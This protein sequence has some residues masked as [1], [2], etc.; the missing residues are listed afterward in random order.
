MVNCQDIKDK[1]SAWI[2][3]ELDS[4]ESSEVSSHIDQC[5]VCRNKV[6]LER[7]TKKMV[8]TKVT[9]VSSPANLQMKIQSQLAQESS[10]KSWFEKLLDIRLRPLSVGVALAG[11]IIALVGY[12]YWLSPTPGTNSYPTTGVA[13]WWVCQGAYHCHELSEAGKFQLE[14]K[15]GSPQSIIQQVNLQNKRD[16][17]MEL[18]EYD[19]Q[20]F[21]LVGSKFC[22]LSNK[23]SI[24][25][26]FQCKGHL[27][28]LEMINAKGV[29]FKFSLF[30]LIKLL[31]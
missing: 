29:K 24:Y 1:L 13:N 2:D 4:K 11:V 30:S 25:V 28:S 17:P 9:L 3:N 12:T 10:Q 23:P 14:F 22:V 15:D 6:E 7:Y 16:F 21:Q 26:S 18:P 8:H 19:P 20:K 27:V 5:S 31:K